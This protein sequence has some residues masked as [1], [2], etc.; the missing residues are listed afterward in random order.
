[1][2]EYQ[3]V[4]K[5]VRDYLS[6]QRRAGLNISAKLPAIPKKPTQAS[7]RRLKKTLESAKKEAKVERDR[8]KREEKEQAKIQQDF[9]KKPLECHSVNYHFQ[10]LYQNV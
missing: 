5:A 7:I 6:R 4:R 9:M 2:T 10:N 8:I 1:M 3:R